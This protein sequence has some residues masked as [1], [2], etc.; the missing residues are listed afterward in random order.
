MR[1]IESVRTRWPQGIPDHPMKRFARAVATLIRR[2][3][4]TI[5]R[6]PTPAEQRAVVSESAPRRPRAS[7]TARRRAAGSVISRKRG[8]RE[9]RSFP[10]SP[11]GTP[12][13]I[14]RSARR[15]KRCS[16]VRSVKVNRAMR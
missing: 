10:T 13:A 16:S 5:P 3:G 6:I 2:T 8:S 9:S 4:S 7:R 1:A 12:F 11:A 14:T 15:E